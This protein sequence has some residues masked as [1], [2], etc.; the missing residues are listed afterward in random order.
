MLINFS[1]HPYSLW[2]E[3]QKC[4][5]AV[6]GECI[7]IPF[8]VVAPQVSE[9]EIDSLAETYLR[10]I[11]ETGNTEDF[12]T[13]H[14]MGEFTLTYSL[15]QKLK[16]GNIVCIASCAQRNVT[17]TPDGVKHVVF[18]FVRFRKF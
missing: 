5:A 18:D 16:A 12:I 2:S 10:K 6:Y 1:N 13:V 7:D 11:L 4:A 3:K 9:S 17:E 8:P 14:I 15:I